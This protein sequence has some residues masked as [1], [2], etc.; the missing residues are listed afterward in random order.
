MIFSFLAIGES[1]KSSSSHPPFDV[2]DVMVNLTFQNYS[3][4][5]PLPTAILQLF[6]ITMTGFWFIICGIGICTNVCNLRT[7]VIM[8]LDE[9]VTISFFTLAISDFNICSIAFIE[10][11]AFLASV[12]ER[13]YNIYFLLPPIIPAFY[14]MCVRRIFNTTTVLITTFLAL[15][16]CFCVVIPFHVKGMF[17]CF[18]TICFMVC[19]FSF[20]TICS[21]LYIW[22]QKVI[23]GTNAVHNATQLFLYVPPGS[24]PYLFL[25]EAFLGIVLNLSCQ[26][27]I[28][29]CLIIMGVVLRK[30]QRFRKSVTTT[31]AITVHEKT[32]TANSNAVKIRENSKE[33]QA[34]IQV[35]LVSAIFILTNA[36][37][38]GFGIANL[39]IPQFGVNLAYHNL[40]HLA[41]NIM[42]TAE[43]LNS[44]VNFVVYYKY[45][46]KFR[47]SL[48]L[49]K[50]R[51]A[52][53]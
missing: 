29:L 9:S 21:F 23:Q 17:T 19:I 16:R 40:F 35:S 7:F 3:D 30:S 34:L 8:G 2:S 47:N 11:I 38:L 43:L 52:I 36:P 22:R 4:T 1:M 45:N 41:I 10:L 53:P 13:E 18:R 14:L 42:F 6:H 5:H 27:I 46:S 20:S 51:T 15:Q 49:Q 26:V 12:L 28:V 37:Y 39:L 33:T 25:M 24:E 32:E 48:P 44:S 31:Q 50:Q